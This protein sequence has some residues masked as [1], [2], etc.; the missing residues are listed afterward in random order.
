MLL[1]FVGTQEYASEHVTPYSLRRMGTQ[2]LAFFVAGV[3]RVQRLALQEALRGGSRRRWPSLTQLF[4]A[5][6]AQ[7]RPSPPRP[8]RHFPASRSL[9]QL[10]QR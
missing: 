3:K 10:P 9:L 2:A 4:E 8:P 7:P 1:L 5:A 6:Q